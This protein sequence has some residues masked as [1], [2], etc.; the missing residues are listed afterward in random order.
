M[1]QRFEMLISLVLLYVSIKLIFRRGSS[2]Q[3]WI[4]P[5]A[6]S[7][8]CTP[9]YN[10]QVRDHRL[11]MRRSVLEVTLRRWLDVASVSTC[12]PAVGKGDRS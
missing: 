3:F 4:A 10:C 12:F 9:L 11:P 8:E 5:R 6:N 2:G 7:T 1:R